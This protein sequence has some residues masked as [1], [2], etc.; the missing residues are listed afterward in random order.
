MSV[1][2]ISEKVALAEATRS[3]KKSKCVR[4]PVCV[5]VLALYQERMS[6][7]PS[8]CEVRRRSCIQMQ[9]FRRFSLEFGC[10]PCIRGLSLHVLQRPP[11]LQ[12]RA[13]EARQK[14]LTFRRRKCNWKYSRFPSFY[15][16]QCWTG[17][18]SRVSPSLASGP[19]CWQFKDLIYSQTFTSV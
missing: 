12:K 14:L 10:S 3:R 6:G 11:P 1:P 17:S 2:D 13:C 16:T 19:C 8:C 5:C 18:L 7:A 15:L 4:V 9:R